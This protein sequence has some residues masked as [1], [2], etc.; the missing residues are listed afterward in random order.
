M[1][2]TSHLLVQ[3]ICGIEHFTGGMATVALFTEMMYHCRSNHE[4][5]DYTLQA[6]IVVFVNIIASAISGFIAQ[7]FGYSLLFLV[8]A[9]FCFSVF[10]ILIL[11]QNKR[12][13]TF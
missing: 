5:T 13:T 8:C 3:V 7:R 11:Y 6:C 2:Q 12:Q 10:P 1:G 4:A 9:I